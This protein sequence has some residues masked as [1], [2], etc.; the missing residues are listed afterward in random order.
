MRK[1][2]KLDPYPINTANASD[3]IKS[4]LRLYKT[5]LMLKQSHVKFRFNFQGDLKNFVTKSVYQK[6]SDELI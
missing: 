6:H 4:F 5:L 3:D 2:R 1:R